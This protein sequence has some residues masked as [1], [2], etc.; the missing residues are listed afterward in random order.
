MVTLTVQAKLLMLA[1][2]SEQISS[3]SLT[4]TRPIPGRV[5]GKMSE[6]VTK[7]FDA[8]L[9]YPADEIR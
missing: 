3:A 1:E 7:T 8:E 9:E 4:T 6:C 2:L 5:S